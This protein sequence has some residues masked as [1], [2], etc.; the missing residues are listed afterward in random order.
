MIQYLLIKQESKI[1]E[2]GVKRFVS[3][4]NHLQTFQKPLIFVNWNLQITIQ[5]NHRIHFF[6]SY[7]P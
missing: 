2:S 7:F 5:M 4:N 6:F 1:Q 3:H